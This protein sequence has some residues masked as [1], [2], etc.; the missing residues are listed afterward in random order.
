MAPCKLSMDGVCLKPQHLG[1]RSRRIRSP[2]SYLT[3]HQVQG[4]PGL[5][6]TLCQK[7]KETNKNTVS[8]NPSDFSSKLKVHRVTKVPSLQAVPCASPDSPKHSER[9]CHYL[10]CTVSWGSRNSRILKTERTV[11]SPPCRSSH[12]KGT[13]LSHRVTR[14][15]QISLQRQNY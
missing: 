7:L 4:Q 10:K 5:P 11:S 9:V 14:G 12:F 8:S 6:E 15:S 3:T 1:G 13:K 2:R